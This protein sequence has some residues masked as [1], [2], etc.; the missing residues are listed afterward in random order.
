MMLSAFSWLLALALG[1][2]EEDKKGLGIRRCFDI[3]RWLLWCFNL[4]IIFKL[5]GGYLVSV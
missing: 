1:E 2:E 3:Q 4:V 5:Y